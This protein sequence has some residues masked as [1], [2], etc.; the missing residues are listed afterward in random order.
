[1]FSAVNIAIVFKMDEKIALCEF[2][3]F[4][5]SSERTTSRTYLKDNF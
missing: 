2:A 1:M 5:N 4:F 3:V